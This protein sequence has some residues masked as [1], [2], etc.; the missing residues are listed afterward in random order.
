MY[1]GITNGRAHRV[2]KIFDPAN[3]NLIVTIDINKPTIRLE[4]TTTI[5]TAI[6]LNSNPK[7]SHD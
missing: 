1:D 7:T 4:I 6:V 5:N 2:N 3:S